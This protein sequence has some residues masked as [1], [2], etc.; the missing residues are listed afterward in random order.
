MEHKSLSQVEFN[1]P[2]YKYAWVSEID[3]E[4]N[5]PFSLK[6][7]RDDTIY[8]Q[9]P[10]NFNDPYDCKVVVN[11]CTYEE[12][13]AGI[14][15]A[16]VKE[17]K[18]ESKDTQEQEIVRQKS[19][20][21]PDIALERYKRILNTEVSRYGVFCLTP[22]PLD[23]LMWA[24]Y[25][26]KHRGICFQVDINICLKTFFAN[27]SI[28]D[29]GHVNYVP[30]IPQIDFI[31]SWLTG[32]NDAALQQAREITFSKWD[33]W[34]NEDEIRIAIPE[35]ERQTNNRLLKFPEGI[36]SAV[37]L[38]INIQNTY[39]MQTIEILREKIKPIPLFKVITQEE[40]YNL[41]LK[42]INY[43]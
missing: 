24:H 1:R 36:Y 21:N 10:I 14:E 30:E 39:E 9:S 12:W 23:M 40:K 11:P 5:L 7:L 19:I 29:I 25:G 27:E 16:V 26:E 41:E 13:V 35:I 18:K 37:I 3:P 28:L 43:L 38:G 31:R 17:F 2:W 20:G 8:F 33:K 22:N 32:D 15:K 34:E 4:S 42:Q 6:N